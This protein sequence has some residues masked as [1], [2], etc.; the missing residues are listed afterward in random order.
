MPT[1][2][3]K[4]ARPL[5]V[6]VSVVMLMAPP[7]LFL[8]NSVPCGPRSTSTRWMSVSSRLVPNVRARYTPSTYS[9]TAGSVVR[10]KSNCPTP[11]M[12]ALTC[13]LLPPVPELKMRF[14]VTMSSEVTR[15]TSNLSRNS[16]LRAVIETGVVCRFSS[17]RCAVTVTSCSSGVAAAAAVMLAPRLTASEGGHK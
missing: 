12:K 6:G 2:A 17:T 1:E 9:P 8:P 15:A 13:A 4:S 14:G 10:R 11:R 5:P 3:R 7:M 16:P